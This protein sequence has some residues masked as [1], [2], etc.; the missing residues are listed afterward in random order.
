[1]IW[2]TWRQ[3]RAQTLWTAA[4][5]AAAAAYILYL[6]W[7]IRDA[8]RTLVTECTTECD[9]AAHY[10]N[11]EF[12]MPL[13]LLGLL[14]LAGL[15]V[16]GAFWGAPLIT[17][18]L[19]AGTHRLAWTQSIT[20]TRWLTVKLAVAGG[21]GVVLAGSVTLLLTWA[22]SPLDDLADSRF[23]PIEFVTR[24]A[25]PF[26]YA[27]LAFTLGLAIGALARR[28]LAAM[29]V[30]LLA[31]LGLQLVMGGYVRPLYAEPVTETVTMADAN[32][33]G[34]IDGLAL[35][36]SGATVMGYTI[37][38]AWVISDEMP[39]RMADGSAFTGDDADDCRAANVPPDECMSQKDA[40]FDV[41]YQ[42]ADRYWRFQWTEVAIALG[43]SA[44]L[45][46][47]AYWRIRRGIN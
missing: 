39:V 45:T 8:Y 2:L 11:D 1:M 23:H 41:V 42:P 20:R 16:F 29:A 40:A 9:Q 28:T 43:L 36:D 30:T 21:A 35:D 19:E 32:T 44:I 10:L 38:G 46:G 13:T 37:P 24:N 17:R 15:A 14:L 26:G 5:L 3:M 27:V 31:F 4:V 33:V 25:A 22:V 47:A 6:A 12:G 34:L 7:D 18:E